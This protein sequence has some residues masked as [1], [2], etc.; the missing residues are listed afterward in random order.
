ME[1]SGAL[2]AVKTYERAGQRVS[3]ARREVE[4]AENACQEAEKPEE[5]WLELARKEEALKEAKLTKETVR[6]R[7]EEIFGGKN[8]EEI[9]DDDRYRRLKESLSCK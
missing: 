3:S 2:E 4:A 5:A 1:S 7:L 9:V 6:Q 8:F